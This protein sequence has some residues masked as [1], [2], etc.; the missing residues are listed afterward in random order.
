MVTLHDEETN[1]VRMKRCLD[2]S[3]IPGPLGSDVRAQNNSR[4]K[5][6][7]LSNLI[8][9]SFHNIGNFEITVTL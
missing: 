1:K 4:S 6:N 9:K 7:V 2:Y 8:Q 5:D 3:G